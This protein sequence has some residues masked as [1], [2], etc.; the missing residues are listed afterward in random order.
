MTDPGVRLGLALAAGGARGS[1]HVGVLKVLEREGIPVSV[2]AGT[3]IG[4][5]VGGVFSAGVAVGRIE[6]EWLETGLTKVARS[7]LPTFPRV[8]LSSGTELSKYLHV[9][10]GDRRIEDLS[11]PFA[12][13][14]CDLDTGE[15][16]VLRRGSAADALRASS[17]IPGIFVPVRLEGRLLVDG[18]LVDPLPVRVCRDLGAEVVVGV[19]VVPTPQPTTPHGRS[20]WERLARHLH[21]GMAHQTWIPASLTEALDRA[22]REGAETPPLPG[23]YGI[24]NQ[25]VSILLQEVLRLELCQSPPDLLIRP[26]LDLSTTSYLR[27]ADGIRAGEVAAEAELPRLRALLASKSRRLA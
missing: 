7:F 1:A 24:L 21:D 25:S 4:A 27:A 17:S 19:D 14:A 12:A 9:L 18:G 6:Q 22:F 15:A 26:A 13:V 16:V 11:I 2:V 10:L 23:V 20:L 3:S 8:G 5:V